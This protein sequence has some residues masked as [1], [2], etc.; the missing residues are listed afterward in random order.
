MNIFFYQRPH[1]YSINAEGSVSKFIFW[2]LNSSLVSAVDTW[3][4]IVNEV[5]GG[6]AWTLPRDLWRALRY[7][8]KSAEAASSL[9]ETSLLI[10]SRLPA[11]PVQRRCHPWLCVSPSMF[12]F[13]FVRKEWTY[14]KIWVSL[15]TDA[16]QLP[17]ASLALLFPASWPHAPMGV[18]DQ[19]ALNSCE[20]RFRISSMESGLQ[21][22]AGSAVLCLSQSLSTELNDCVSASAS[23]VVNPSCL[24][25]RSDFLLVLW[26]SS[27]TEAPIERNWACFFLL[28][29][30]SLPCRSSELEIKVELCRSS[31]CPSYFFP[32]R[33]IKRCTSSCTD[34]S[35]SRPHLCTHIHCKNLA[36]SA[37]SAATIATEHCYP[38]ST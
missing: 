37:T 8:S 21:P 19:S 6:S 14:C 10:H 26:L 22:Y 7:S 34:G 9:C 13:L 11:S 24:P 17:S 18:R 15:K 2:K 27:I 30:G 28:S 4:I 5:A 29:L 16:S 23:S 25:R 35:A 12:P 3:T 33:R 38:K 32:I 1:G 31:F 36:P 20:S